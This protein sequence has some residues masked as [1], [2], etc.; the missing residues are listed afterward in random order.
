LLFRRGLTPKHRID[1][2]ETRFYLTNVRQIPELRFFVAYVVQT[3]KRGREVIFPR[4][5][6]KDLSL[7]WRSAS[8]FAYEEDGDIWIGKGDVYEDIEDGEHVLISLE[9]TTDLPLE[10]QT[11]LEG[12]LSWTKRP[13][14]NESLLHLVLRR[15]ASDRVEP[16]ADFT[17]P[18]RL[19]AS[20]P[21]NLIHRN[22]KVARFAKVGDPQSLRFAKGF[23]PD[24]QHG[25]VE[26][27]QSRS[28]MY[29]GQIERFRILSSNKK[30]QYLFFAGPHHVWLAPPQATTTELS[31]YGVRTVDVHADDDLFIP[32]YEYHHYEESGELYS[33]IPAGYVG[34]E[35][36]FDDAK[37][38]ASP[39]LN[40]LPIIQEFRRIVL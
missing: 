8:H 26:H 12:L 5:F 7:V 17:E 31:S 1:L 20:N 28:R 13:K 6:Y 39:W 23:E 30:I 9:S 14:G 36:P 37:A 15:G 11:A 18:R 32:G 10:M 16:F 3:D 2:F 27:A 40:E 21:A 33:Q 4:I 29:G 35:C 25:I 24:L 19:A 34:E 38:D 22:R